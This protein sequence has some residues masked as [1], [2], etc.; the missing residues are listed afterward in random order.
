MRVTHL[1]VESTQAYLYTVDSL[2]MAFGQGDR[3]SSWLPFLPLYLF[4]PPT[5]RRRSGQ[6]N[7]ANKGVIWAIRRQSCEVRE[8]SQTK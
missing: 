1:R 7:F 5:R 4:K 2:A 8:R 3:A 6:A